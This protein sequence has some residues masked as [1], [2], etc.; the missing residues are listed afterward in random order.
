MKSIRTISAAT[1]FLAGMMTFYSGDAHARSASDQW[2]LRNEDKRRSALL[3]SLCKVALNEKWRVSQAKGRVS[4]TGRGRSDWVARM[5]PNARAAMQQYDR[6]INAFRR[7]EA[8]ALAHIRWGNSVHGIITAN[9]FG[10]QQRL[11]FARE[12][13]QNL[14]I[15]MN[16]NRSFWL[17]LGLQF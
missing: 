11:Q 2:R 3:E 4:Q 7:V 8:E 6:A 13:I 10:A 9:V 1:L 14:R 16:R 12:N 15:Q 17:R 5:S